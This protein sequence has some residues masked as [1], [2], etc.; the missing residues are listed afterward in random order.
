MAMFTAAA[1]FLGMVGL[2]T[3]CTF[4]KVIVA[5]RIEIVL[6]VP[7]PIHS[8]KEVHYQYAQNELAY[9]PPCQ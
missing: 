4:T 2:L 7:D 1:N 3:D 9:I 5:K 8:T 6:A